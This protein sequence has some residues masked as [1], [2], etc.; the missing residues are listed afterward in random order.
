MRAR[1]GPSFGQGLRVGRGLAG[2]H[3]G[4]RE[5]NLIHTAE[6]PS[7]YWRKD[8]DSSMNKAYRVTRG[9]ACMDKRSERIPSIW[10]VTYRSALELLQPRQ[11]HPTQRF[12]LRSQQ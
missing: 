5:L 6:Y 11:Q 7:G 12:S 9:P 3:D 8:E 2:H 10:K 1:L 4:S